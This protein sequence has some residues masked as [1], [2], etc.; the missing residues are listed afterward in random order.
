MIT[1]AQIHQEQNRQA[2]LKDEGVVER[3]L[4]ANAGKPPRAEQTAAA[5]DRKHEPSQGLVA[6]L[7]RTLQRHEGFSDAKWL[8]IL[9]AA[10]VVGWAVVGPHVPPDLGLINSQ[11][12][13]GQ[14][15]GMI[16]ETLWDTV[17]NL[18]SA[19]A[20][21]VLALATIVHL[22][23]IYQEST[24]VAHHLASVL[25]NAALVVGNSISPLSPA[26]L[27]LGVGGLLWQVGSVAP[28]VSRSQK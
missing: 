17:R 27:P 12:F 2:R 24:N 10:G 20:N 11:D 8:D 6:T 19:A 3:V 7:A 18:P 22:N 14:T 23:D 25:I 9:G 26:L 4:R 13:I 1:A 16:P 21:G 28:V 15:L 5:V